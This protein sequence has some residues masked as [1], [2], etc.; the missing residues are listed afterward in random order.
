[1]HNLA[2]SNQTSDQLKKLENELHESM[3]RELTK[4]DLI[5]LNTIDEGIVHF[6]HYVR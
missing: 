5:R 4:K 1:M 2:N 6:I 3:N